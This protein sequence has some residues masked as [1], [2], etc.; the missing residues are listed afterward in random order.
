MNVTSFYIE[1]LK[2]EVTD[3]L[4]ENFMV[5]EIPMKEHGRPEC[6]EQKEAELQN[7]LNFETFD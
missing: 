7:L 5:V 6:I 2:H 3:A 4:M 1:N